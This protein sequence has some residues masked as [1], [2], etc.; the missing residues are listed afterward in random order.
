MSEQRHAESRIAEDRHYDAAPIV[1]A[2]IEVKIERQ[3]PIE[4]DEL[5]NVVFDDPEFPQ[6]TDLMT[7]TGHMTVG[8]TVTA[9]ASTN[10][11][12]FQHLRKDKKVVLHVRID[13][14][15]VSR[16]APYTHWEDVYQTF[17]DYWSSYRQTLEPDA[18]TKIGVRYVNRF[19]LPD[20]QVELRDYFRTYPEVSSDIRFPI[21]GF[22][23]HLQISQTDIEAMAN[24]VLTTQ[25][26][27]KD[28]HLSILLDIGLTKQMGC[29]TSDDQIHQRMLDLRKRKNEIFEACLQPAARELLKGNTE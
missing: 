11:I 12:G 5:A 18:V 1:E 23:T 22:M 3:K 21:N 8:P 19:N 28:N 16:L 10:Q 7:A 2:I 29:P 6:R 20:A 25:S 13:G 15:A 27:L 14:F 17:Q 24:I 4:I 26:P 9:S